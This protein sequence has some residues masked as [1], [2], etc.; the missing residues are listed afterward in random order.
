MPPVEW[1]SPADAR[2]RA[3]TESLAL[4]VA[5]LAVF[6]TRI[7]FLPISLEDIDS[8]NFD[9]GVHDFN[10]A[11]HQ[12]H[13]PGFPVFIAL[14]K[15][16]HPWFGNHAT[17]LGVLSAACSSIALPLIYFLA[18]YMIGRPGAILGAALLIFNPL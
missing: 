6:L 16:V 9:L 7:W 15:V 5:T 13:P 4:A 2:H 18:R 11:A 3:A 8:V 12:P 1:L 14:A 10:P 17:G